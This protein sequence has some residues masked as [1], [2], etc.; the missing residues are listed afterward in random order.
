MATPQVDL[1]SSNQHSEIIVRGGNVAERNALTI[2]R[3]AYQPDG[4]YPD[5]VGIS[6]LFRVGADLDT[7]A[8]ANPLPNPRLSHGSVS[9]IIAELAADGYALIL[10]VTP[11]P[12]FGLPD[13]H[14]L[15]VSQLAGGARVEPPP[16]DQPLA[17]LIRAMLV[18]DNAYRRPRP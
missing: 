11:Q 15:A 9:R 12:R 13:H 16:P 4:D 6:V 2:L 18:T 8:R 1:D 3:N 17:A 5:V 14:T 7:L 10:Y